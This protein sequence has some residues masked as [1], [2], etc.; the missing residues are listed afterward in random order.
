MKKTRQ[1]VEQKFLFP[2]LNCRTTKINI[3]TAFLLVFLNVFQL[4]ASSDVERRK[5]SLESQKASLKEILKEVEKQSNYTF[6]Y[7]PKDVDLK[8]EITVSI[9]NV[10]IEEALAVIFEKTPLGFEITGKQIL[11]FDKRKAQSQIDQVNEPPTTGKAIAGN[12]LDEK[13]QPLPGVNILEKGTTNGTT[14]DANGRFSLTVADEK[15]VIILSFIGYLTSE[16]IV[17][18]QTQITVNLQPDVQSL[19]EVIVVGYGAVRKSDITGSVASVKSEDLN[20]SALASLDQGLTGRAAG[21]QISS[22]TG[23]PGGATSIR[24][25]GGNSINSRNEPLYVID[26]FPYYNDNEASQA[27]V[28]GGAPAVNVLATLNPGD[29]ESI[30]ILKDASATAIYGS[31]GA[32][33]VI[34]ITTKRGKEGKAKVEYDTYIGFQNVIKI[35][36]VL[37]AREYAEF[38]NESFVDG[39]GLNGTGKPTYSPEQVQSFGEGTNWQ[40]ELYQRAPINNHQLTFTGGTDRAQYAISANY[41]DQNGI[42]LGTNLKRYSIRANLDAKLSEKFKFGNSFTASRI[43]TDLARSGGGVSG[44]E[45]V[46]SPGSGNVIQDA[47]FY[48]PTIPVRDE[49]GNFTSNN[50][51]DTN[52]LGGGNVANTPNSNPIAL[53]TLATQESFSNR[54]LETLFLEYRIVDGLTFKISGGADIIVN[55]QNSYLPSTTFIGLNAPNGIA[56]TGSVFSFSWLNENTLSYSRSLGEH[57]FSGLLGFTAQSFESERSVSSGRD[58]P[59]DITETFN[60]GSANIIDPPSSDYNKWSLLSYLFRVNYGFSGKYLFTFSG[61]TDGSSKF[62]SNNKYGFF[63]SAAFAWRL[64]EEP[65]ISNL[66][67]FDDFKLR[68][69]AGITGNQEIPTYQS[70]SVLS[71]TRYAINP[72]APTVGLAPNRLGNPDIKWETT[73][74]Y[75]AGLD[76]AFLRGRVSVTTDVYYKRTNDLLLFV[77]LPYESGFATALTNIGEVE[78]KGFE[79]AVNTIN[80]DRAIKWKSSFN[81]SQNRNKVLSFGEERE[82]YIGQDYNLF[83]GQAVSVIRVGE[84]VGNFVG[85]INDG[86]I[87]NAEELA[88]APK[89]G[90]DNIGSRRYKDLNGDNIIDDNDRTVIGNALPNFIGGFQNSFSYKGFELDVLFQYSYG[91]DVYNMTQLELEFLN[92]RQNNSVTVLDRFIPGVNEDTDVARTGNPDYSYT[93]QSHTRWVEDGSFLRLRNL[94]FAYNF[95][96]SKWDLKWL[97]AARIYFNGQNLW[98]LSGY[99]GYD[100]EVNINPQS[101]TLL[102]FDY[103]SYPSAKVYTFGIK[104]GF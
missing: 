55:K 35:L 61:R 50:N 21:V 87:K 83:K 31:R 81:I 4:Q 8:T 84:P 58:F 26:G 91:N 20:R 100:P 6:F 9:Q 74:Q 27:G 23:Q 34:L 5:V 88:V 52:G 82:R 43:T 49:N 37:N 18:N 51:S 76:I 3:M 44:L 32:N 42:V 45:G 10:P 36:P 75:N 1:N 64:V 29:I 86:I 99:R 70:L 30:E 102:G 40:E 92:G 93:R 48:N 24:I 33:G 11:L 101:N 78:N 104:L 89:S 57:E 14:T 19:D 59:S 41:F 12:V 63:P 85:Y 67:I 16:F 94:T 80:I 95:P 65:F 47:L 68:L 71:T 25:R 97:S 77:R 103:A 46:Q 17:G 13:N 73:T 98:L 7:N 79:F 96:V 38:R 2:I 56:A 66:D 22:Q 69:S 53:Q 39:R 60:M 62:G 54:I 28:I 72:T 15:S 90:F